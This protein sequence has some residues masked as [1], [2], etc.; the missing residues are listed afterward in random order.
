VTPVLLEALRASGRARINFGCRL[1]GFRDLG[2]RVEVAVDS[3]A[4]SRVL[5]GSWLVGADGARSRVRTRLGLTFTGMTYEDRFL[6][7]ATTYELERLFPGLGP[8]AY[9]FDPAEWVILMQQP[10]LLRVIFRLGEGEPENAQVR[11]DRLLGARVPGALIG[12]SVYS[13][14]QRVA[15]RFRTGRV[16]LAGDAA[17]VNNP[18]GGFGMNS[19]IHDA[20]VLADRLAQ[21][22]AG[23]ASESLIDAYA[24]ER[25]RAA[26]EAVQRDSDEH[27]RW[28]ASTDPEARRARNRTL[29]EAA[30]DAERAREF[31]LR[32]SMLAHAPRPARPAAPS[33]ARA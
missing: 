1:T 6:L 29:V 7:C 4:G 20:W 9:V 28:L 11:I 15:E 22:I 24:E 3:A 12:T 25:R 13:V 17:H 16:V 18:T 19:G 33:E 2:A 21:V 10:S 8:V 26:V 31:L 5:T 32:A 30:R 27:Y 23:G 14:H